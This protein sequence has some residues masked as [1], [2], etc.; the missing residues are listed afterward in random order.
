MLIIA[1]RIVRDA[2]FSKIGTH[3]VAV[4]AKEH[5]IPFYIAAPKATFDGIL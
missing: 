5:K 1:I 3:T 2:V 4:L